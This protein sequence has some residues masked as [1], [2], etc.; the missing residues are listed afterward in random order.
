[1][2]STVIP[3]T[4]VSQG[5][6]AAFLKNPSATLKQSDIYKGWYA[7]NTLNKMTKV[8][9]RMSLCHINLWMK[10]LC[11][12]RKMSWVSVTTLN[13]VAARGVMGHG[14]MPATQCLT[15]AKYQLRSK[16]TIILSITKCQPTTI[17]YLEMLG[18]YP[19]AGIHET[20]R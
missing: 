18:T 14:R 8:H 13:T 7:C 15:V 5:A 1:M 11:S 12:S 3:P 9:C 10:Y 20:V 17:N 2:C 19:I 16:I 4:P 6:Q